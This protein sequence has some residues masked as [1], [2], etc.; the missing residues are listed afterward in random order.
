MVPAPDPPAPS[1]FC[2]TDSSDRIDP[3][4]WRVA[5][6][7]VLGS[8]MSILDT[9]IVNVA[10]QTL[11]EKLHSSLSD[12]QWVITGYLLS[13]ATVIPLTGW[14]SRR[15]GAKRVYLFALVLFTAGSALCGVAG[16]TNGLIAFRVLQG[17]G[18]GLIMPVG[19]LI[20]AD[21]AGP[22]R[23][24][25]VMSVTGVPTMLG[26]I[27]GPTIGGLILSGAS[28]RWIFYVNVPIG[29]IAVVLALRILP[30]SGLA[31]S[32]P[33]LDY[34]GLILMAFGMPLL[35]Y[36]LAEI[37]ILDTFTATRVV[38][39]LLAGIALLVGFSWYAWH[40]KDAL[41]DLHL[42]R[43][44]TYAAASLVMFFLGAALFGAIIL[45]PLYYQNLRH[46]SVIDTGLLLG[47]QGIGMA[48]V[49]PLVGRLTDRIGGGPLA[50]GGV[51]LTLLAGIPLGLIGAHTSILWLSFV[52]ALRG[53]GIGFAFMPSFVAAFAALERHELPDAAPQL[54]V[55]MRVGGSIGVAVLAVVLERALIAASHAPSLAATAGAY[56]TAFWWSFALSVAA[57]GPCVW[58]TASERK[59]KRARHAA[60]AAG[61]AAGDEPS[62]AEIAA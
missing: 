31:E 61:R 48:L 52:T 56:G 62:L 54:N 15:F 32:P 2:M 36:G 18:G 43:R 42:Y 49:M 19:Q 45:L 26:P 27:L 60:A 3:Y 1:G 30:A 20:L 50:L 13:L 53:V 29:I 37:G 40:K 35:T 6:V 58:L 34:R 5:I 17:L 23:M 39:P 33:R 57:I 28:W 21:T 44:G 41:L 7:V 9:T 16:S 51:L 12:I 59:A 11:H 47:P 38:L 4:V 10:L 46:E 22:K 8:I 24:G 14:A 55:L 25:R